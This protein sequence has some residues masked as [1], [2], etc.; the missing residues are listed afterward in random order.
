[1]RVFEVGEV[2][3]YIKELLG[4]DEV[5]ADLWVSGEIGNLS[6]SGAGHYYFALKDETSQIRAV[7]FRG[8]ALRCG[9]EPRSGDAVV[10]HGKIAFYE[11]TGSCELCVDLL[12][13]SGVGLAQLRFEALRLKL[14]EEGL[15]AAERKR[16]LPEY[17][18]RIGLVTSEGGVVLHDVLTVLMRRYP[19]A[20]VV[21]THSAVQGDHAP[22]ELVA[23]LGRLGEWRGSDG[24]GVDVVIVGRGGGSPEELAA[25]ND[26]QV[27]RAVF[28]SPWPVISAVGHETDVTICDYVADLRAPTP[29]AAAELVAPD[30]RVLTQEVRDLTAR[31]RVAM[32][33]AL[34]AAHDDLRGGR[35]RLLI[36][37]PVAR[38]AWGRR[39]IR[40][41][42][43]RARL[44]LEHR[45]ATAREQLAGR[46]L[47]LAALSPAATLAR[48]YGVVSLAGDGVV[49]S[50]RDVGI[51]DELEIH[52]TDGVV[53][54]TAGGVRA[55]EAQA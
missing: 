44:L 7:L 9:A 10:A 24:L 26:E 19:I 21:F 36:H 1:M 39:A 55:A 27:V 43:D 34:A 54:A 25:F 2:G 45:L 42:F 4:D 3:A 48:G 8:A 30:L 15:F 52:L 49:R 51:G 46:H 40:Q 37:A 33:V 23:A 47:Q 17:P 22:T 35:D 50:A 20:E 12:Y 5:L 53:D 31:G 41:E 18:R 38:I 13:P 29:S 28:A 14:E 11:P 6:R 32:E 16:A